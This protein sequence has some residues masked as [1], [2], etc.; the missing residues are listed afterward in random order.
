M[1]KKLGRHTK[2]SNSFK[3]SIGK[4]M[5]TGGIDMIAVYTLK[6]NQN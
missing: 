1:S 4:I 6:G 2:V 5:S 3:I